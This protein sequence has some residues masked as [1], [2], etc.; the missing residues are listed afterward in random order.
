MNYESDNDE[1]PAF[2]DP[3]AEGIG[4]V[5]EIEGDAP[6]DDDDGRALSTPLASLAGSHETVRTSH[7]C[8]QWP[9]SGPR[10]SLRCYGSCGAETGSRACEQTVR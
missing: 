10:A 8:A 6:M 7:A 9:T 2:L 4:K 3:T 1:E 5:T